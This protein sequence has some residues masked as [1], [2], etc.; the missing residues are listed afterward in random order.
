MDK[1]MKAFGMPL[2]SF[3]FSATDL[4]GGFSFSVGA[5]LYERSG[6]DDT[7]SVGL[8]TGFGVE[9]FPGTGFP[10]CSGIDFVVEDS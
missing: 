5:D 7:L 4:V 8:F 9:V 2:L 10:A 1:P 6:G 3:F